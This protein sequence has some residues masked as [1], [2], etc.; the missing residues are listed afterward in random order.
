VEPLNKKKIRMLNTIIL[1]TQEIEKFFPFI[2][3]INEAQKFVRLN[4]DDKCIYELEWVIKI[5]IKD[6]KIKNVINY[7]RMLKWIQKFRGLNH[8]FSD[9]FLRGSE[10]ISYRPLIK[11]RNHIV[12]TNRNHNNIFTD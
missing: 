9:T 2:N 1:A 5:R 4:I 7:L 11:N 10:K 6:N 12:P 8:K 3:I